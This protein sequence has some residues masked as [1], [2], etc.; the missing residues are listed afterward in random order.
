MSPPLTAGSPK[1][2]GD[3]CREAFSFWKVNFYFCSHFSFHYFH[4]R[5][6]QKRFA[7]Q[8]SYKQNRGHL[9]DFWENDVNNFKEELFRMTPATF[10]EFYEAITPFIDPLQTQGGW[11]LHK[12]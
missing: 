2:N 11:M 3:G 7:R 6:K 9:R 8:A 1:N 12:N 10:D 5:K 4:K